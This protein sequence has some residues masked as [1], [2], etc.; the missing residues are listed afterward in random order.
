MTDLTV[1]LNKT[2]AAPI[3]KVFDAW[4]DADM[5]SRFILPAPGMPNPEVETEAREGGR[6]SI[7]MKVGDDKIPHNGSYL[8]V[9]RPT[10]LKFTWES[11]FSPAGSTV[12]LNFS[13]IDAVTT[14]VELTHVK[15]F[16]EQARSNHEGGWGNICLLY[17][18]D[19]AD[20]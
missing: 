6:F 8:V 15:F 7:V 14:A 16:D 19:A 2:I 11:P 12:T 20:E 3:E 17:T 9:N 1:S 13:E 4:L 18:S 10:Q 5:L